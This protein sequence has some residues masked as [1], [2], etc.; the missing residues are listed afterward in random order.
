MR[1]T[2]KR[3]PYYP[4]EGRFAPPWGDDAKTL[5]KM[6]KDR[7]P[8]SEIYEAFPHR[9]PKNIRNKMHRLGMKLSVLPQEDKNHGTSKR[10]NAQTT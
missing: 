6:W 9:T 3:E 10:R 1:N 8:A 7:R 2:K 4:E 5:F